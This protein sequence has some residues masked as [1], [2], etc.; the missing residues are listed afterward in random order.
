VFATICFFTI[1]QKGQL[2]SWNIVKGSQTQLL[3]AILL[4]LYA[5]MYIGC[6]PYTELLSD[7]YGY[8][9]YYKHANFNVDF[10]DNTERY[11]RI[12]MRFLRLCNFSADGFVFTIAALYVSLHFYVCK[13]WYGNNN[14]YVAL[15]FCMATISFHAYAS[16]T[17]RCG[18]AAAVLLTAFTRYPI[19]IRQSLNLIIFIVLAWIAVHIHNAMLLSLIAF[20]IAT[21]FIRDTKKALYIW[22]ICIV[23]SLCYGDSIR[24]LLLDCG[25]ISD[26]RFDKYVSAGNNI[27]M[28][29]KNFRH[30]G[31]R[32]DFLIYSALPIAMGWYTVV[33][34]KIKDDLYVT[35]LNTYILANSFWILVITSAQ[36][37]RFAYT[38]WFIYA[39]VLSY[40]LLKFRLFNNQGS[41]IGGLLLVQIILM[42]LI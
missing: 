10:S 8:A 23:A 37:D 41:I 20:L 26:Q 29:A 12:L 5:I 40:P 19:K 9:M 28:M 38:S 7:T 27:E 13:K 35:L 22:G 2:S 34:Q 21:F 31:F 42:M 15:L 36:S 14:V 4:A 24:S 17:L 25:I 16:N 1:V 18:L 30:T 33:K 6:R 39:F 3:M 11:W 32:W